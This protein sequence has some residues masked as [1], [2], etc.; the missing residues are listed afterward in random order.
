[1]DNVRLNI[2]NDVSPLKKVLMH[3][4]GREIESI[5][6][7]FMDELLFEDIPYLEGLR[8][9]HRFFCRLLESAG[10]EVI[11]H[12]KLLEQTLERDEYRE[13]FI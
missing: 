13:V 1:M 2:S 4:P 9:E 6:P 5:I 12:Q 3:T 10:A 11:Y 8:E 7:E